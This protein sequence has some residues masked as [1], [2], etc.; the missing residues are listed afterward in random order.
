M[1]RGSWRWQDAYRIQSYNIVLSYD[2]GRVL[3]KS[4]ARV[5][6]KRSF[7]QIRAEG[8]EFDTTGSL[9]NQPVKFLDAVSA[10][11][12]TRAIQLRKNGW[13]FSE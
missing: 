8:I 9:H 6:G 5:T 10:V 3:Y 2:T 12:Y 4:G 1:E 13:K 11:G 7:P